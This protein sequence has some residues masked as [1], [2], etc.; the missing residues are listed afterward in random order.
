MRPEVLVAPRVGIE[1]RPT[2]SKRLDRTVA[3]CQELEVAVSQVAAMLVKVPSPTH[4]AGVGA[5]QTRRNLIDTAPASPANTSAMMSHAFS[6]RSIRGGLRKSWDMS[7][8]LD[9]PLREVP[10]L[11]V[12]IIPLKEE[13]GC[14]GPW[15]DKHARMA[16]LA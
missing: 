16:G 6:V 14:V 3:P 8:P 11:P 15:I 13:P 5:V 7:V 10:G 1:P 2:D 9:A 4:V 12:I